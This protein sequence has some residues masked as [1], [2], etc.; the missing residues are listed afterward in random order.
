[1]KLPAPPL[2]LVTDR[3]QARHDLVEIVAAAFAGGCRW[4]SLREKDLPPGQQQELLGQLIAAAKPYGAAG[5]LHGDPVIAR[6]AHAHGA[7]IEAGGDTA[8]ARRLLGTDGLIG[9]SVHT[10]AEARA[11]DPTIIDY[12]IAGPAFL[13]DSKPGYGPQLMPEGL[14][15]FAAATS[16]P[17]IAIGGIFPHNAAE[18][19]RAGA[20]GVAV[21]GGVMRATDPKTEIEG[22]VAA[23][24]R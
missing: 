14:A 19:L 16:I 2:L 18:C 13:T 5:T 6:K 12:L 24:K 17:V 15:A 23:I 9:L 8:A 4:V 11:A 20:A 22:L 3:K 10:V 21:M 1:V 7:H